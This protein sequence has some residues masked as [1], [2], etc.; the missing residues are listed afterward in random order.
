MDVGE[1]CQGGEPCWEADAVT[2]VTLGRG[3]RGSWPH[4]GLGLWGFPLA[5]WSQR[6]GW[7]LVQP[8]KASW[9]GAGQGHAHVPL[10]K[11]KWR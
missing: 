2:G 10:A 7:D 8:S 9:A 1:L 6:A 4:V 11:T 3:S 5:L